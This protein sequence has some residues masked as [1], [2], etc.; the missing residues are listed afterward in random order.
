MANKEVKLIVSGRVQG[1]S[2]RFYVKNYC[3]RFGICGYVQNLDDGDV[4]VIAQSSES[5]LNELVEWIKKSPG[6]SK[7]VNVKVKFNE[8]S[9]K[10]DNFE[11]V[12]NAGFINDQKSSFLNLGRS[13][14]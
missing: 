5:N 10:F 13:L 1:V 4:E 14:I 6:L 8:V 12:R 11:I 3:D 9:N 2:L 7:V